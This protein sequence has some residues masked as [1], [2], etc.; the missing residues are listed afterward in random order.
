MIANTAA[1]ENERARTISRAFPKTE[2]WEVRSVRIFGDNWKAGP[3]ACFR[4]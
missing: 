2:I 3:W 4:G 1:V